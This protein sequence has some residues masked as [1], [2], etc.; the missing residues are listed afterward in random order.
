MRAAEF[1]RALADV[2]DALDGEDSADKDQKT[3]M[4]EPGIM[5]PPL[6]QKVELMKKM[7]DVPSSSK[8][9]N[10]VAADEDEPWE[11]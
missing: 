3:P 1:M 10:F 6:Q 8:K 7:A 11:G 2:I 4:E 5:V 9:T